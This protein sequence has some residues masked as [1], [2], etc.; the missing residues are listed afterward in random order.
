MSGKTVLPYFDFV[1]ISGDLCGGL[2]ALFPKFGA[3]CPWVGEFMDLVT[4]LELIL[5]SFIG[6]S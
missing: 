4:M 3:F 1:K 2:S 5:L 6:T